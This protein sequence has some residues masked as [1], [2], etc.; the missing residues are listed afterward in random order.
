MESKVKDIENEVLENGVACFVPKG[1]SMR[2]FIIGEKHTVLVSKKEGRLKTFDVALYKNA[3]GKYILHRIFEVKEDGYIFTGDFLTTK[4]FVEENSVFAYA[5]GYFIDKK[6]KKF[7]DAGSPKRLKKVSKYY[8][9]EK[10]RRRYIKRKAR[11]ILIGNKLKG[12]FTKKGTE[13]V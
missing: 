5:T 2:P 3:D 4:E 10:K 12:V 6:H 7:I 11:L 8:K 1:N 9:N 13:N